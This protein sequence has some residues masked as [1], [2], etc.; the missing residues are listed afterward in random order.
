[1][2]SCLTVTD[3]LELTKVI[4]QNVEF[5]MNIKTYLKITSYIENSESSVVKIKPKIN[6]IR[7]VFNNNLDSKSIK[8]KSKFS[9]DSKKLLK[10]KMRD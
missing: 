10:I 2:E 1:M 7:V 6:G 5:E 4:S 8:I 9:T 3:L